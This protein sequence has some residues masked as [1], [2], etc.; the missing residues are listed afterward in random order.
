MKHSKCFKNIYQIN[1][2]PVCSKCST[3]SMYYFTGYFSILLYLWKR[4]HICCGRGDTSILQPLPLGNRGLQGRKNIPIFLHDMKIL[5]NE[6]REKQYSCDKQILT[7]CEIKMDAQKANLQW[8]SL[9]VKKNAQKIFI[10]LLR[11]KSHYS[12]WG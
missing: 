8:S 10:S 1:N 11:H 9:T 2:F 4:W 3:L 6:A 7:Y 12:Y 5:S